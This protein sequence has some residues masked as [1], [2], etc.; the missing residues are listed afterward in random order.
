MTQCVHAL[1]VGTLLAAIF[2]I[3]MVLTGFAR[4]DLAILRDLET[5]GK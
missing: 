1:F 3:E 5:L 2:G 4:Q